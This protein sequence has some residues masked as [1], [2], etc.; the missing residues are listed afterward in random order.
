MS[1]NK[2]DPYQIYS[3]SGQLVKS[4]KFENKQADVSSLPSG[5]YLIRINNSDVTG[6][7]IK[8]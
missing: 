5:I 3:M 7:F 8:R 2:N 4:G 1:E 6:K